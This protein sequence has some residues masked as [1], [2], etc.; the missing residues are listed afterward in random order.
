LE[1][2]FPE[3]T[4][5]RVLDKSQAHFGSTVPGKKRRRDVSQAHFG[6]TVPGKN[7]AA[8]QAHFGS[9]VPG[10]KSPNAK[11]QVTN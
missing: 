5:P 2:L 3:K 10:K 1:V 4:S 9:T 11:C 7:V 8:S 6:S